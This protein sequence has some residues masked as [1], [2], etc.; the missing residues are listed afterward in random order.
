MTTIGLPSNVVVAKIK[1]TGGKF[2]TSPTAL[3]ELKDAGVQNDV[4]LVM[5][6]RDQTTTQPKT[7]EK[8]GASATAKES[9]KPL[10]KSSTG[11]KSKID[12]RYDKFQDITFVRMYPFA[13][14]GTMSL[15]MRDEIVGF[16]AGF[17]FSGQEKKKPVT[18][19]I[20]SLLS[21]SKNWVFLKDSHFIALVDGE[22][23]DF[24]GSYKMI[25]QSDGAAFKKRLCGELIAHSLRKLPMVAQLK[26]KLAAENTS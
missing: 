4:I 11:S 6:E 25:Q 1:K 10:T 22:R 8:Q 13:L 16:Q 12:Q 14:S 20:V 9:A 26:F 19:G 24:R 18:E 17:I 23:I 2:D 7:E 15:V 21:R 5:I 3:K